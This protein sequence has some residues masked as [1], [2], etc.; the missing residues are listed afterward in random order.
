MKAY[1]TG[2]RLNLFIVTTFR[3]GLD[4]LIS[5]YFVGQKGI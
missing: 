2:V 3:I 5:T 1:G 4:G